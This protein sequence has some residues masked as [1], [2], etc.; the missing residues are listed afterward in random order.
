MPCLVL[1][2]LRL[3]TPTEDTLLSLDLTKHVLA[4]ESSSF[5]ACQ[6]ENWAL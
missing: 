1:E 6:S 4:P 2:S 5:L 3:L